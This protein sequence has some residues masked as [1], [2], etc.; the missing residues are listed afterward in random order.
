MSDKK[1]EKF[2]EK[3]K[4]HS[5]NKS[6][7]KENM[8]FRKFLKSDELDEERFQK[9]V[10]E[11]T[12]K[13]DC[14]NCANCCKALNHV[15]NED[16]IERISKHLDVTK[17]DFVS[18]YT[19]KNKDNE[20]HIRQM[21]C[22]FLAENKCSKYDI[23]PEACKEYPNLLGKDVTERCLAFFNNAEMCQIAYNVLENAKAEFLEDIYAFNNP[24]L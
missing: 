17:E 3:I 9:I 6:I 24:Y 15:L 18:K 7:E 21:P 11:I 12:E 8:E 10:R 14:K 1:E 19:L 5:K 23:R 4:L 13:I 22:V 16:D 20:I 2:I